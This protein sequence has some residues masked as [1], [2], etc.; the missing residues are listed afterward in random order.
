MNGRWT[1]VQFPAA[2]QKKPPGMFGGLLLCGDLS[3]AERCRVDDLAAR[4]FA[5][6]V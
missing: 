2:P 4:R 6:R 3:D 5:L 1:R